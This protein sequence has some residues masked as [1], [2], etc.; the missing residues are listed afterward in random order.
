VFRRA[1]HRFGVADAVELGRILDRL[2]PRVTIYGVV[3]ARFEA[4]APISP[5]VA[6]AVE[7]LAL[8]L[9][10]GAARRSRAPAAV[11]R[12]PGA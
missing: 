8:S 7:R 11:L 3:G 6:A 5:E 4:G 10:D 9:A 1:A 12:F 2:P